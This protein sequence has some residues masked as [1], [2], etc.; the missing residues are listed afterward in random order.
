MKLWGGQRVQAAPTPG[1]EPGAGG[2]D[3]PAGLGEQQKGRTGLKGRWWGGENP[4]GCLSLTAPCVAPACADIAAAGSA[5][6]GAW[7]ATQ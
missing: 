7:R 1:Q 5:S 6:C 2:C 4:R 3:V